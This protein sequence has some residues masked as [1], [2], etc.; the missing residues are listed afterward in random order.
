[1]RDEIDI[2]MMQVDNDDDAELQISMRTDDG[3]V[4][5]G[6]WLRMDR[7]FST[8]QVI[9][10]WSPVLIR[11]TLNADVIDKDELSYHRR[12]IIPN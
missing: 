4:F 9:G 5:C 11:A 8:S 3:V 10:G 7:S 6:A 1:M 12:H 2:D